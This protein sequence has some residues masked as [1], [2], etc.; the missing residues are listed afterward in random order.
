MGILGFDKV[1][2]CIAIDFELR[3]LSDSVAIVE[4][5]N[6]C[7]HNSI[8]S[9]GERDVIHD[10]I[11]ELFSKEEAKMLNEKFEQIKYQE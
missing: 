9:K 11:M 4:I 6:V 10:L 1:I 8:T 2:K 5:Q 7:P 3:I